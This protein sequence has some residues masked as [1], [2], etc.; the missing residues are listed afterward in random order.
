MSNKSVTPSKYLVLCHPLLLPSIFPSIRVFSS[1]LVLRMRWP[2]YWSFSFSISPSNEY[3]EWIYIFLW[4]SLTNSFSSHCPSCQLTLKRAILSDSAS[5][6]AQTV[7]HLPTVWETRVRSLGWEDPL[8]KEMATHSS[9]LAW[10]IPWKEKPGRLQSMGSQR[11]GRN[12]ATS[13]HLSSS[14]HWWKLGYSRNS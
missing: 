8:E 2:K 7:K 1:E 6:V 4:S 5:L 14:S 13:P 3:S 10:K 12:W 9:T 11:V